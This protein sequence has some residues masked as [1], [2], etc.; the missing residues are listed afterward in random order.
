VPSF[1]RSGWI[2]AS[3]IDA[4]P[5]GVALLRPYALFGVDLGDPLTH[6]LFWSM[7]VNVGIYV[8]LSLVTRQTATE[9]IQA[10]RF[11]EVFEHDEGPGSEPAWRG[12][13]RVEDLERVVARFVGPGRARAAFEDW[14][15]ERGSARSRAIA[16]APTSSI[17]PSVCSPARSAPRRRG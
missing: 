6:A 15:R 7:A 1:A 8:G 12:T 2:D 13:A 16:R 17:S 9:R 10:T 11:V 4:G 5:W 3:F 14:T